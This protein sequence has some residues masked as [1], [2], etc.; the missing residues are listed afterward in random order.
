M[1]VA[2]GAVV[3]GDGFV[4]SSFV[5]VICKLAEVRVNGE[6]GKW[7]HSEPVSSADWELPHISTYNGTRFHLTKRSTIIRMTI[8]CV[9]LLYAHCLLLVS[10]YLLQMSHRLTATC[11]NRVHYHISKL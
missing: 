9:P 5:V 3:V 11:D 1:D 8:D 7:T 10:Q 4:W 6:A 2:D